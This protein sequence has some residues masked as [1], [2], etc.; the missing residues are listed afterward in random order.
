MLD[1]LLNQP[2]AISYADLMQEDLSSL[3]D[4]ISRAFGSAPECLGLII[5]ENLPP[6]FARLRDDALR[7][8]AHFA[9]D[10]PEEVQDLYTDPASSYS[11]GWSHGKGKILYI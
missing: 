7:A 8:A 4:D 5:L 1:G 9:H 11:F 6:S 10:V 3:D 2:V